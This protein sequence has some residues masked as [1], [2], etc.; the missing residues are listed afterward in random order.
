MKR[1]L[2]EIE[3]ENKIKCDNVSCSYVIKS[4]NPI[5][6]DESFIDTPCPECGENLLT[7]EDYESFER[8]M[9]VIR[10]LNK[11]FSW[12]TIFSFRK[13]R[14][15]KNVKINVHKGVHVIDEEKIK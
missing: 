11:W 7:R 12:L 2:I 1:K 13:N 8:L 9:K 10:F 4:D 6:I 5:V 14:K 15:T 3:Q